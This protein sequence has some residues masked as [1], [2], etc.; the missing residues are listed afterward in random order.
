MSS[1]SLRARIRKI[2]ERL[3]VCPIHGTPLRC[4]P[5]HF[6]WTGTDEEFWELWP[7][8]ARVEAWLERLTPSGLLC[9]RCGDA[10]WCRPCYETQARAIPLPAD[11]F[12]PAE[13]TR[14]DKLMA[15]ME[16]VTD[17]S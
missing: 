13:L 15:H 17:E 6:R 1:P 14:Y 9:Q 11:L 2:A 4:G 3:Q 12:T 8:S 16:E 10:L 7:L 5:C